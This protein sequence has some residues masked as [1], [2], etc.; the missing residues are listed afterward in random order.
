MVGSDGPYYRGTHPMLRV[1]V[2]RH[3]RTTAVAA[4]KWD[5]ALMRAALVATAVVRINNEIGVGVAR[6]IEGPVPQ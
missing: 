2:V 4:L 1:L 5:A 6:T 3:S